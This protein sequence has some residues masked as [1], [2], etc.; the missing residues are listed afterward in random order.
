MALALK[1]QQA[2]F[3]TAGPSGVAAMSGYSIVQRAPDSRVWQEALL[4]TNDDGDISTNFQSYTELATGLCY[5]NALGLLVD[6]VEEVDSAANG[7]Q[8][9]QGPHK[10]QWAPTGNAPGGAVTVTLPDSKQLS[11]TVYGMAYFDVASGSNAPI[12]YVQNCT[13]SILPPNQVLYENAFSNITA[14]LLYTYTKAGVSQDV[15]L[16]Q[17]PPPPDAYGLSDSNTVLQ[18]Y[19][20]FFNTVEPA[21]TAVT[22]AGVLDD[23]VLSFGTM[24]MGVGNSL[25]VDGNGAP[26]SLA[27]VGKQWVHVNNRIF[28]IESVPW[29]AISNQVGQLHPASNLNLKQASVRNL[30]LLEDGPK[31]VGLPTGTP[32]RTTGTI[33]VPQMPMKYAKAAIGGKRLVVDWVLLSGSADVTLQGDQT[34]LVSSTVNITDMLSVEGGSVVKFTNLAQINVTGSGSNIVCETGPYRPS[35]WTSINDNSVG[36]TI[37]GS[38]G[39]P[40]VATNTYLNFTLANTQPMTLRYLRFSYANTAIAGP[41][42]SSGAT[43]WIKLWDCQFYDCGTAFSSTG[44]GTVDVYAYNVLFSQV[45]NG[46]SASATN[47]TTFVTTQNVTA[48]NMQNFTWNIYIGNVSTVNSIF[49]GVANLPWASLTTSCA[50]YSSSNGVYTSVGGASYYLNSG[51]TNRGVGTTSIDAGLLADLGML[52]TYPPA[53]LPTYITAN[54]NLAQMVQRNAG[55]P[56]R[57]YHYFPIDYAVNSAI[58][59]SSVVTVTIASGTVLA[60]YGA[61]GIY[62]TKNGVLDCNGTA[63][64]P[65]WMVRY[66]TVQE[67]ST[68]NWTSATYCSLTTPG[69]ADSSAA[70]LNFT[71]WSAFGNDNQISYG[72]LNVPCAVALENCQMYSG[73]VSLSGQTLVSS[74]CLYARVAGTLLEGGGASDNNMFFNNLLWNGS[75]TVKHSGGGIWKFQDNLFDQCN[76]TNKS[77]I[78]SITCWSNAYATNLLS[79]PVYLPGDTQIVPLAASPAYQTGTLGQF[80]YPSTQTSLVF[81]GSQSASAARL[82]YYTVTPNNTADGTN[83]VSIGFHY[84][85]IAI[86]PVITSEPINATTTPRGSATFSVTATGVG[87]L[88]YQWYQNGVAV[89]TGGTGSTLTLTGVTASQAGTYDVVITNSGGMVVSSIVVLKEAQNDFYVNSSG[90]AAISPMIRGIVLNGDLELQPYQENILQSAT[91][92]SMR[93]IDPG[94]YAQMYDWM[95]LTGWINAYDFTNNLGSNNVTPRTALTVLMNAATN[96]ASPIFTVNSLG[97][98]YFTNVHIQSQLFIVT[99]T[100]ASLLTNLAASWVRYDNFIVQHY[101]ISNQCVVPY[102]P[103]VIPDTNWDWTIVTNLMTNWVAGTGATRTSLPVLLTNTAFTV[104]P[105]VKYWEIGN[106]VDGGFPANFFGCGT[107]VA[108][109]TYVSGTNLNY[110]AASYYSIYTNIRAAMLSAVPSV[111]INIGPGFVYGYT[112][113]STSPAIIANL[114]SQPGFSNEF[115]VYHPYNASSTNLWATINTNGLATNLTNIKFLENSLA[116]SIYKWYVLDQRPL[117]VPLLATE[118][119]GADIDPDFVVENTMWTMLANTENLLSIAAQ[120]QTLAADFYSDDYARYSDYPL[121]FARMLTN[122]GTVFLSSSDGDGLPGVYAS[123][124]NIYPASESSPFRAYSTFNASNNTYSVWMLNLTNTGNQTVDLHLPGT[125]TNGMLFTLGSP[126]NQP[127][128]TNVASNVTSSFSFVWSNTSLTIAGSNAIVMTNPPATVSVAQFWLS[129]TP[130][131][132]SPP[133][134]G[135]MPSQGQP[136]QVIPISGNNFSLTAQQ[137]VVYFGSVRG[138][139]TSATTTLLTVQVPYGA[140]YGPVTV[141]VSNLTAYSTNYFN[142]AYFGA[143]VNNPIVMSAVAT[144]F[145]TNA[146]SQ[147]SVQLQDMNFIDV[148]GDGKGDLIYVA[149]PYDGIITNGIGTAAVYENTSAGPGAFTFLTNPPFTLPTTFWPSASAFGDFDGDGLLDWAWV[150]HDGDTLNL[151][152]NAST[153]GS[154]LFAEGNQYYTGNTPYG[155]KVVDLDGDGK[156][157]VVVANEHD[158]TVSVYR[159]LS[160]GPGNIVFAQKVDYPACKSPRGLAVGDFNGDGKPDIAV[161][162]DTGTVGV[163]NLVILTNMSTSG[164]IAFSSPIAVAA[165]NLGNL[166]SIALGDFNGDG[167]LD[168]AVGSYVNNDVLIY[169]NNGTSGSISFTLAQTL[170]LITDPRQIAIADLNGDG[171]PDMA[172]I[173]AGAGENV[174]YAYPNVG[175]GP[176]GTRVSKPTGSTPVC[177]LSGDFDGDGRPDL[178]V[179]N[180]GTTNVILFQNVSQY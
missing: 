92:G 28:L 160:S 36:V 161:V 60:G 13:G 167:K 114:F 44:N 141:T 165:A 4:V 15:V 115:V 40:S 87:P 131:Q 19:S 140:T 18:V 57:G 110:T 148:D 145:L 97:E 164:A 68:T 45:T 103:A 102:G 10:V 153:P 147:G 59:N 100:S 177:L 27:T 126:G 159:N 170:G 81:K 58:S 54:T 174:V 146:P 72:L 89:A 106:E 16:R 64:S 175:Q 12:A 14:D 65:V 53:I 30:A 70:T 121:V 113:T 85:P 119:N 132:P 63:T 128:F 122:L 66:N 48:D 86:G 173:D 74:N 109:G 151:F 51:S 90:S 29:M 42:S 46:L 7:A 107:N 17:A 55:T 154:V 112:N 149:Q 180:Y 22:N 108:P 3:G 1:G 144:N 31:A 88:T 101:C 73:I 47:G 25:F 130:A 91:N 157:D 50:L 150:D 76:I 77:G 32:T 136:G 67:Q 39:T 11:C 95:N 8:A 124:A 75:L 156:P 155:V 52:T 93:G 34:Y 163:S 20:E 172:V 142:P 5:T 37:A 33:A 6:T 82:N 43:N 56:D 171:L 123:G 152:R 127:C 143:S 99:N 26:L 35:V 71:D 129:A 80:Y 96:G 118:W 166:E 41:V 21:A 111:P 62:L 169:T 79:S 135:S 84:L 158:N 69:Q 168:I 133:V 125:V 134:I 116:N 94:T 139:V 38:T 179:G 24:A 120:Q 49:T 83:L 98:G 162:G 138:A 176:F 78:N 104:L 23:T 9:V 2:V 137:N 61:G 105:Q 178:A 117:N